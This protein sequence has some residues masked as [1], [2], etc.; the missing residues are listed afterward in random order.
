MFLG[1]RDHDDDDDDDA[2]LGRFA[3]L[4]DLLVDEPA[5]FVPLAAPWLLNTAA[6]AKQMTL[7]VCGQH[8]RQPAKVQKRNDDL[9]DLG[10]RI[11]IEF[12][13]ARES[14]FARK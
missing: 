8:P 14:N 6:P 11:L 13:I 5:G 9:V 10:L 1:R 3:E 2:R 7:R 4:R 12:P